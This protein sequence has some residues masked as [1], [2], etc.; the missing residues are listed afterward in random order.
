MENRPFDHEESDDSDTSYP[1]KK[2]GGSTLSRYLSGLRRKEHDETSESET[3]DEKPRR[4]R[5]IFSRLFPSFVEK[6]EAKQTESAEHGFDPETWFSWTKLAGETESDGVDQSAS[7]SEPAAPKEVPTDEI[8]KIA[9]AP[10]QSVE[11]KEPAIIADIPESNSDTTIDKPETLANEIPAP[12][13]PPPLFP[14]EALYIREAAQTEAPQPTPS[15]EESTKEVV[16]ERGVGMALPVVLVGAEYLARKKADRKLEGRLNEKIDASKEEITHSTALQQELET[17]VKQNRDQ[18]DALKR[19]REGQPTVSAPRGE[20]ITE[21]PSAD[22]LE[23]VKGIERPSIAPE[24]PETKE[25]PR[26]VVERHITEEFKPDRILEQ[27]A[28]AAEHDIPIERIFERSHEI[29]DD[30]TFLGAA[31]SVGAVVSSHTAASQFQAMQQAKQSSQVA[32]RVMPFVSEPASKAAYMEAIKKG[33]WSAIMIIILGSIA[34][35][36]VK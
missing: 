23:Q 14:E 27:V 33:F 24:K 9:D 29:K 26:P 6:P 3:G 12:E 10:L 32:G 1:K 20:K 35:L 2:R 13:V 7:E 18:L 17:V 25:Q 11:S 30:K 16:V 31:P 22:R 4:L 21:Q 34:Y 8:H 28:D 36:M 19:A 5:R 15:R